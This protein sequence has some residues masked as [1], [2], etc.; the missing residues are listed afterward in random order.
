MQDSPFFTVK[1]GVKVLPCIVLFSNGVAV[2]R[3]VGFDEFGATD[4]FPT[5]AV[6]RR[7]LRRSARVPKLA[8]P[9]R[10]HVACSPAPCQPDLWLL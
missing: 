2:D 7:L 8:W 3:T 10:A 9:L 4:D 1:L 5:A 6:E